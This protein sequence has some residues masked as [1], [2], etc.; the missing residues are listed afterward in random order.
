MA[1]IINGFD[2]EVEKEAEIVVRRTAQ[3]KARSVT[4]TRARVY[5]KEGDAARC[6][7]RWRMEGLIAIVIERKGIDLYDGE[8]GVDSI[9]ARVFVVLAG[10]G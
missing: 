1:D 4:V 7:A 10:E 5:G 6:A 3:R 8:R 2:I 9:I